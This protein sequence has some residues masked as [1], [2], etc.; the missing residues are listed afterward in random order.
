[1]DAQILKLQDASNRIRVSSI[2]QTSK[3]NS[4]HPTSSASIAEIMA[5]L[6]FAEMRY[7]VSQLRSASADRFVL[8]KVVY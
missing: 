7:D 3:A 6:F 8:S 1:M 2:L 5:T 4:G